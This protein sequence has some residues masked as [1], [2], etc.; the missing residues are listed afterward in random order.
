MSLCCHLVDKECIFNTSNLSSVGF[1]VIIACAIH[2]LWLVR[3]LISTPSQIN[4]HLITILFFFFLHMVFPHRSFK[5]LL[6]WCIGAKRSSFTHC[7]RTTSTC[8]L[9]T[10]TS[11]CEYSWCATHFHLLNSDFK[12]LYFSN[13]K[14]ASGG[15][16]RRVILYW[17]LAFFFWTDTHPWLSSLPSS[18]LAMIYPPC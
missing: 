8:Y 17:S 18:F 15:F 2:Q 9:L 14:L 4:V 5:L 12:S 6:T 7:V 16:W 13:Q 3:N 1:F 10:P 11:A